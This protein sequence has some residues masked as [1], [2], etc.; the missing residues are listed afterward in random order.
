M[1]RD[2]EETELVG[3]EEEPKNWKGIVISLLVIVFILAMIV[4]A[5]VLVSEGKQEDDPGVP[6]TFDMLTNP[7]LHR[8][9]SAP[10]DFHFTSD[11]EHFVSIIQKE[12]GRAITLNNVH[13]N[14]DTVEL[15]PSELFQSELRHL[16]TARL[17]P[18][19]L[20][21]LLKIQSD[22]SSNPWYYI[23]ERESG[24]FVDDSHFQNEMT[25][26]CA[27]WIGD[28]HELLY[29]KDEA[30]LFRPDL[31]NSNPVTISNFPSNQNTITYNGHTNSMYREILEKDCMVWVSPD[32]MYVAFARFRQNITKS[33]PSQYMQV[34]VHIAEIRSFNSEMQLTAEDKVDTSRLVYLKAM[35]WTNDNRLMVVWLDQQQK[36][37]TYLLCNVNSSICYLNYEYEAEDVNL[38]WTDVYT[39][40]VFGQEATDTNFYT[41]FPDPEN[42][43]KLH[44]HLAAIELNPLARKEPKKTYLTKHAWSDNK[45]VH[46]DKNILFFTS[47]GRNYTHNHLYSIN[48]ANSHTKCLTCDLQ[49]GVKCFYVD[50]IFSKTSDKVMLSCLG[51][52]I[53]SYHILLANRSTAESGEEVALTYVRQ[54]DT[55]RHQELVNLLEDVK[56]PT[57]EYYTVKLDNDM[58]A[59][60]K[61]HVPAVVNRT[62]TFTYGLVIMLNSKLGD[63]QLIKYTLIYTPCFWPKTKVLWLHM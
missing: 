24:R 42:E 35:S 11:G 26:R 31:N 4:L 20:Y 25:L 46:V 6:L 19:S 63:Q 27:Y 22:E 15:V 23:Y 45:I 48:L 14:S 1:D 2:C 55:E 12:K 38:H 57:I 58:D 62:L 37:V 47:T 39:T 56:L 34:T 59:S 43:F 40:P 53:P 21:L 36:T 5:I 28:Q 7:F 8:E 29:I 16:S 32:S 13:S 51:P 44:R 61:L 3:S 30:I 60:V 50:V 10:L 9:L 41:I 17:S 54:I 52:D 49:L 18:D 33:P